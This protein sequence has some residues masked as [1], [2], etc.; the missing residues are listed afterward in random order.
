MQN[1]K[2][3][4][5]PTPQ[6]KRLYEALINKGVVAKLEF[7]DGFKTVDIAIPKAKLFIEVDGL[8]H[9]TDS[10]TIIRDLSR[11]HYTDGDDKRT[12]YVTNQILD[13]YLDEVVNALL[14]VIKIKSKS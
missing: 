8:N 11:N 5:T 7:Y 10:K 12:F 14:E 1:N 2:R 3:M 4:V 9:F 6:A 13:K